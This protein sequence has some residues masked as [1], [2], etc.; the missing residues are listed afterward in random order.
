MV[1]AAELSSEDFSLIYHKRGIRHMKN[2]VRA[3]VLVLTVA[4]SA[5]YTKLT[6][7]A[8]TTPTTT[9]GKMVPSCPPDDPAACHIRN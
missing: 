5:A 3:F 4:G 1:I 8:P 9:Q 2:I 6:I 7:T